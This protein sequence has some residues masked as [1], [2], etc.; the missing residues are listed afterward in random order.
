M[1]TTLQDRP[2]DTTPGDGR[3][4]RRWGAGLVVV[5]LLVAGLTAV[6]GLDLLPGFGAPLTTRTVDRSGPALMTALEDLGE[7]HAAQATFQSVVDLERDTRWVPSLISG[8]RTT[9]L[10]TGRV[11]GIADFTGLG[12]GAVTVSEDG[13]TVRIALPRPRLGEARVDTEGSRVVARDRGVLDRVGGAFVDNPT[14]ERDLVLAAERKLEA[15]AAESDL[16]RRTAQNTRDMLTA[17]VRALGYER[18]VVT[19]DAGAGL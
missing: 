13:T 8:E 1:A 4:R 3:G 12:P 17:L 15:A 11:D 14:S 19:F 5:A 9:Y 6:R 10:A 7:Y 16:L 18:V 2:V